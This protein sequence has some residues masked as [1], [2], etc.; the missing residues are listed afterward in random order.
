MTEIN[1]TLP[2]YSLDD[3]VYFDED[4]VKLCQHQFTCFC[5]Y[6]CLA[7]KYVPKIALYTF[8]LSVSHELI[9]PSPYEY[10]WALILMEEITVANND[11]DQVLKVAQDL[12]MVDVLLGNWECVSGNSKEE[13]A[14]ASNAMYGTTG[15]LRCQI[16]GE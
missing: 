1:F 8:D 4:L 2:N 16:T 6:R 14:S 11:A 5:A 12:F 10:K 15:T 9:K 3:P 13:L 7:P